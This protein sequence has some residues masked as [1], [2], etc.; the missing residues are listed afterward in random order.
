MILEPN[1]LI[2]F[3]EKMREAFANAKSE[4]MFVE[5]TLRLCPRFVLYD[6]RLVNTF[7]IAMYGVMSN[8]SLIPNLVPFYTKL[9][10]IYKVEFHFA[11]EVSFSICI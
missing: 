10:E 2:F 4:P 6:M 3:V 1:I 11:L 9:N 8:W 5:W 7:I